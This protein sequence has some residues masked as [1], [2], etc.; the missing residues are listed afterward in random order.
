V[1]L[2]LTGATF[3]TQALQDYVDGKIFVDGQPVNAV[4]VNEATARVQ[5][6][7]ALAE[8]LGLVAATN[9]DH[10]ASIIALQQA[11][12]TPGM[13]A[14]ATAIFLL[15]VDGKVVGIRATNDGTVGRLRMLFDAYELL[16]P[17]GNPLLYAA[18]G[19][20]KMPAVEVDTL[21]DNTA[22]T[23]VRV[24]GTSGIAGSLSTGSDIAQAD[25]VSRMSATI[26]MPVPGWIEIVATCKQG[27]DFTSGGTSWAL[28]LDVN[29]TLL[30]EAYCYGQLTQDCVT[31]Q[32]AYYAV[33]AGSYTCNFRWA[34]ETQI[35]LRR[36]MLA[37]GFPGTI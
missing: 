1:A 37:K 5:G 18:D 10:T 36:V 4:V 23:P 19:K 31:V 26:V 30:P 16:D 3:A 35:T 17:S 6:D 25:T 8:Q 14:S 27:F 22:V 15:D 13:G 28:A 12:V 9:G 2:G 24:V 7:Q 11:L 34:G 21:K 20:V 29:G 33:S 32:G